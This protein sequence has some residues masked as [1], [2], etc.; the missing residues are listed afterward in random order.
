LSAVPIPSRPS[1]ARARGAAWPA[2]AGL[3][4]LAHLAASAAAQAPPAGTGTLLVTVRAGDSVL[5]GAFVRSGRRGA[6]ADSLGVARLDLPGGLTR[7]LVTHPGHRG[8]EFEITIVPDAPQRVDA[9]LTPATGNP[10]EAPAGV[11]RAARAAA[12]DPAAVAVAGAGA[13]GRAARLNPATL[14]PL[15]KELP[16]VR[17][18][19]LAGPLGAVRFRLRG[20]RGQYTDVRSD[21]LPLFGGT[22]SAFRL[23]QLGPMDLERVEVLPGAASALS[24]SS[25]L[26]GVVD[27]VPRR[28]DRDAAAVA[29]NQSSEKGGGAGF[30]GARRFSP[31]AGGTLSAEFHQQRLVDSDDDQWG[32]FPRAIR[33]AVRPRLFLSGPGGDELM[34]TAGALSEDRTGGFLLGADDRPAYREELRTRRF[35][36]GLRARRATSHTGRVEIR[37]AAMTQSAAHRFDGLRQRDRRT[38]LF[39]EATWSDVVGRV[40]LLAGAAWQRD[41]FSSRDVPGFDY[42]YSVPG[43]FGQVS[44]AVTPEVTATAAGRCDAHNVFGVFCTPRASLLLRP[45]PGVTAR[46]TLAGGYYAPPPVPDEAEVLGLRALVPVAVNFERGQSAAAEMEWSRDRLTVGGGVAVTR[47]TRPVR[48]VPLPGDPAGRLRALNVPEPTRV[49]AA[50]LWAAWHEDPVTLRAFYG[51]LHGTEGVP[52]GPGRRETDLTPRHRVGASLAWQGRASGTWVEAHAVYT[53]PQAVWD[54]PFRTRT[55]GYTVADLV[56]SQPAGRARLFASG[57]NLLD[58]KQRD[59]EPILLPAPGP[60]GRRTATPWMPLQG[61]V[62]RLGAVV[63]W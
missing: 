20:V 35:D 14:A 62:I 63:E 12:D 57:E 5:A 55:P 61:R 21:G 11:A 24:G 9:D 59:H 26:G 47:I 58:V 46:A 54:N 51:F 41:A 30:W 33:L 32:E 48:L 16:G 3:A 36:A 38:T 4:L 40:A 29:V 15:A 28:A 8:W 53:G 2:L 19:T 42:G 1:T 50:D 27:L 7:V 13:M 10:R 44:L 25:A 23:S 31:R 34:V 43:V 60:G 49:A 6:V 56:V 52:D 17:A 22:H 45:A 39:A 37:A 18:V